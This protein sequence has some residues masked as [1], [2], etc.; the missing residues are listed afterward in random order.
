M[1]A[2]RHAMR[3]WG[4]E[5]RQRLARKTAQRDF[6]TET[7][8]TLWGENSEASKGKVVIVFEWPLSGNGWNSHFKN[9]HTKS[10][11][12]FPAQVHIQ[13][14]RG[15]TDIRATENTNK[16]LHFASDWTLLYGCA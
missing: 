6:P 3:G 10:V 16:T 14:A 15:E 8:L 13:H 5:T 12:R 4:T 9:D 2:Q 7:P 11:L 1:Q